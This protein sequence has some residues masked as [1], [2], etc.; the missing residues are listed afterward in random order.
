MRSADAVTL[1]R[2]FLVFVIA[3]LISVKSNAALVVFLIIFMF[4]LDGI[5][6]YLA[7]RESKRA[8][9]TSYGAYI[10]IAGDRVIEYVFWILFSYLS[11]IPLFVVFLIVLR[12]SFAD[13]MMASKKRTFSKMRT[14]FGRIASSHFSRG[15]YAVLKAADFIYLSLVFISNFPIGIGYALTGVVVAFSLVRGAVEIYDSL[16]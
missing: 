12:N 2:V 10:D 3:Y 9:P 15:A 6:G 16:P 5:D 13:A 7:K 11:I 1:F 4:A 14:K 8:K